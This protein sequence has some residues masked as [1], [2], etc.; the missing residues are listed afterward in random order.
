MTQYRLLVSDVDGTLLDSRHRLLPE[1]AAAIRA[2]RAQGALFTLATGRIER[3]VR[4]FVEELELDLPLILYNG[5]RVVDPRTGQC[6]WQAHLPDAAVEAALVLLREFPMDVNLYSAGQLFV[7]AITPRVQAYMAQDGIS[8][9]EVGDLLTFFRT[10]RPGP[11]TKLLMIGDEP[12]F[13]A[14]AQ[15]LAQRLGD[16]MPVYLVKSYPIYLEMLPADASKGQGLRHLCRHL[17]IPL[18]Q[19]VA[20][21]DAPNDLDMLQAAGLGV[22]VANAHPDVLA[23]ADYIAPAGDDAG[24]AHVIRRFFLDSP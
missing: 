5:A 24:V 10:R 20:V 8:A 3:A 15:A 21:G 16:P 22:A 9:R 18:E 7:E 12:A 13:A 17:G 23:A 6:L 14:F 1:N 4:P 2:L 19:V 11:V